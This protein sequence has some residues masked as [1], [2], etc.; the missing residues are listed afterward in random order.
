[1]E[2]LKAFACPACGATK[3][4]YSTPHHRHDGQWVAFLRPGASEPEPVE[5][6]VIEPRPEPVKRGPGRPRKQ[7]A[8]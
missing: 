5:R 6:T 8:E 3:D 1:M 2:K 7:P 4:S